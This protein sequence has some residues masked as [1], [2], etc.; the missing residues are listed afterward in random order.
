MAFGA[1]L[2]DFVN[3]F[4]VGYKLIDSPEDKEWK[5]EERRMKKEGFE[6]TG[7]WH[8]EDTAYRNDRAD[9]SDR[10]YGLEFDWR[11]GR[12]G[13]EDER[14]NQGVR[15]RSEEREIQRNSNR[16][17]M[18]EGTG[19]G[20][21]DEV[22]NF[23]IQGK[24]E[25]GSIPS[26]SVD[27]QT[28]GAIPDGELKAEP[29]SL[30]SS[31]D[32]LSYSNQ[33][34][35]RNLP[36][37]SELEAAL[38]KVLPGLG[39]RA[40]VFSGGQKSN[41]RG[42]GTGSTRHN[43][44]NAADV[45]LYDQKTGRRL[46]W[47]N[48]KDRPIFAEVVRRGREAGLTGFGAGPGYMSAGTMH[49]GFGKEGVWG[50]GG[51]SKNAPQWMKDAYYGT[52]A[53]GLARGGLV[54][55]I[56]DPYEDDD[57]ILDD[58]G[59]GVPDEPPQEVAQVL[60]ENGPVPGT[61]P[62]Y[63]GVSNDS[64]SE[65]DD[66]PTDDPYETARRAVREGMKQAIAQGKLDAQQA[67][68]DPE[69]QKYQERYLRGYG[70]APQQVVK[71]MMDRIDPERKMPPTQRNVLAY[72]N[73][74]R[75]FY[76]RGEPDKA[77]EAAMSLLQYH[78]QAA[79]QY[80]A[81]GQAAAM[82]G[83]LD[84]AAE[85]AV[86]AYANIPNGR[87]LQI[88]KTDGGYQI[89]VTDVK[90]G[91]PVTKEVVAPEQFAAAAAGFNPGTFDQE[92]LN[93]AGAPAEKYTDA[94]LEDLG[95]VSDNVGAA[96]ESMSESGLDEQGIAAMR[97]IATAVASVKENQATPEEAVQWTAA[98]LGANPEDVK[99]RPERGV[100][101]KVRVAFDGKEYVMSRNQAS[102]LR[103]VR[104]GIE[105]TRAENAQKQKESDESWAKTKD[106]IS[107]GI[108]AFS[109]MFDERPSTKN[110]SDAGAAIGGMVSKQAIP[111]DDVAPENREEVDRLLQIR[112]RYLKDPTRYDLEGLEEKL[113][114]LG[115]RG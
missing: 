107:K 101:D 6:R 36:V 56:P 104:T 44:G 4:T 19:G 88:T 20:I 1:E 3:G 114:E 49:I 55:A 111:D 115:W 64:N 5:R 78:R 25:G 42:E 59:D 38:E 35:V 51:R 91:K 31:S 34:A 79:Q 109:H 23:D 7:R 14:F 94:S 22:D 10:R 92:I 84:A 65:A 69:T 112:E 74:Y 9:E 80:L 105:T 17:K 39:V 81:L 71:Q 8:D 67:I 24:Y 77:K 52:Q 96:S 48:P 66:K 30:Q 47:A 98:L 12:A 106:N 16:L 93:A 60:P 28:T 110:A 57:E 103:K 83:D 40:E 85:A 46:D 70:A 86:K 63:D 82:N 68:N 45:R 27:N 43:H 58:D 33:N 87:D 113:R 18:R 100:P 32:W 50:S 21:P 99:I 13:V 72:A 61:R 15:E 102:A 54:S 26:G 53:A 73:T 76:E 75:F 97:Q 108:D 2:R 89:S 95:T 37:S 11:K 90:T 41:R 29:A 62:E